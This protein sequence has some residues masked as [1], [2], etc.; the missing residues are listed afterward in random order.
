MSPPAKPIRIKSVSTLYKSIPPFYS[1]PMKTNALPTSLFKSAIAALAIATLLLTGCVITSVYPFYTAKDMT[2][3]PKLLGIWHDAEETN[4]TP[5]GFWRFDKVGPQT[6]QVTI[7]E[8]EATN[9]FDAHLFTLGREQFLDL[10]PRER[11]DNTAPT[12]LLL[13]VRTLEPQLQMEF[14]N[15]EWLAKL[16]EAKPKTIRHVIVPGPVG[17]DHQEGGQLLL[18]A[19]TA[20]LQKFIRKHLKN[21]NAWAEPLVLK[22]S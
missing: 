11:H 18:T 12:H 21:T 16:V 15:F 5:P 9:H 17:K 13:R 6:Y 1:S 22:K 14:L 8:P 19:D 2:F 10:L 20:E 3:E 7:A 4:A